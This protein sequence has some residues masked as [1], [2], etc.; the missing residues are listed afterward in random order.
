MLAVKGFNEISYDE[1]MD[2]NGGDSEEFAVLSYLLAGAAGIS[3]MVG[4]S[5]PVTGGLAVAAAAAGL[6]SIYDYKP[7][8][9]STYPNG[10]YSPGPY[11]W[12][13]SCH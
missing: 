6:I 2:V 12:S 5:N 9:P 7:M 1:L 10:Y 3:T 8:P 13:S 11:W 4:A